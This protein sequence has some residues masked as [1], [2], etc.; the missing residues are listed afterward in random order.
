MTLDANEFIHRF[1]LHALRMACVSA[2]NKGSDAYSM[3]EII[4][5]ARQSAWPEGDRA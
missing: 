5:M 1:L 2:W 3:I 4:F